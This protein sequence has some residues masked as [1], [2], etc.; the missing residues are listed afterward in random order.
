S[1]APSSERDRTARMDTAPTP[2]AGDP[3]GAESPAGAKA[4]EVTGPPAP[5]PS[6]ALVM[7]GGGARSAYQVG[8][9]RAVANRFPEL[10]APIVTGF[11]A[12]AIHAAHLAAQ[13]RNF[14]E[15]VE[16]LALLWAS[17]TLEQVFETHPWSLG[18]NVVRWGI[19]LVSGGLT[20]PPKIQSLVDTT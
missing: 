19:Q 9:L 4:P 14:R 16:D 7:G 18:V 12:G 17:P 15:F 6:L 2:N 13:P 11:S 1:P 3:S 8:F 5:P 10:H 20:G